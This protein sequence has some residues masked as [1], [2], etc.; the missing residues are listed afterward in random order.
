MFNFG[1]T[2]LGK[3]TVPAAGGTGGLNFGGVGKTS[4]EVPSGIIASWL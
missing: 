4:V 3:T 1:G 2:S